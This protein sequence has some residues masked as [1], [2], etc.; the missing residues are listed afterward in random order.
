MGMGYVCLIESRMSDCV[1]IGMEVGNMWRTGGDHHDNW[2]ST[3]KIIEQ[4]VGHAKYAGPGGWNG[5]YLDCNTIVK[6]TRI[7]DL[8]FLMTGGEGC[9][10]FHS[11]KCPG[12]SETEYVYVHLASHTTNAK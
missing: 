4:S 11:R 7:V 9:P 8:D 1:S 10:V 2:A 6:L 12:Q 5:V 3:A